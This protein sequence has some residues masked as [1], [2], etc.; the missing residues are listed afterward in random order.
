MV[1]DRSKNLAERVIDVEEKKN[2]ALDFELGLAS[3]KILTTEKDREVLQDE[4]LYLQSQSM[5]YMLDFLL[6]ISVCTNW[7]ICLCIFLC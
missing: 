5:R 7:C 3:S 4:G 6:L 1:E 2:E